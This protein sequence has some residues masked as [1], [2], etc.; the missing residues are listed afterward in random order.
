MKQKIWATPNRMEIDSGLAVFDRQVGCLS[1]GNVV[2]DCQYSTFIRPRTEITCNGRRFEPG[3][4]QRLDLRGFEDLIDEH[5][6]EHVRRECASKPAILYVFFHHTRAGNRIVHGSLLTE[7]GSH[8]ELAR[9]IADRPGSARVLDTCA[10]YVS[11][12]PR[13]RVPRRPPLRDVLSRAREPR[14]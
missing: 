11:E 5:M 8:R 10:A 9:V 6:L 14:D 2:G 1:V 4:L 7:T 3:E 13:A 12:P